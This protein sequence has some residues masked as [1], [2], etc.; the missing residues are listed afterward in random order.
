MHCGTIAITHPCAVQIHY[1]GDNK[2]LRIDFDIVVLVL[3][4]QQVRWYQCIFEFERVITWCRMHF[5]TIVIAT[6]VLCKYTTI[7][8]TT[9]HG[10]GLI[11]LEYMGRYRVGFGRT[12]RTSVLVR[13]EFE[14]VVIAWCTNSLPL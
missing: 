1:N 8:A 9:T 7:M 6:R 2:R 5:G 10:S 11:L 13:F 12:G 3:D 4:E 14:D